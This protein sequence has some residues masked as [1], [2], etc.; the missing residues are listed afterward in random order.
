MRS[1]LTVEPNPIHTSSAELGDGLDHLVISQ[2]LATRLAVAARAYVDHGACGPSCRLAARTGSHEACELARRLAEH[3][4]PVPR[5]PDPVRGYV[6]ALRDAAHAVYYCRRVAH[7]SGQCWF[8]P[9]G[10]AQ[11]RCRRVLAIAHRLR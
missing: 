11:G 3:A 2:D 10:P 4:P 1:Q 6:R 8:S 9:D 7:A 5:A